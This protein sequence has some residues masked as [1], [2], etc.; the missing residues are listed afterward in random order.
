MIKTKS[1]KPEKFKINSD[2]CSTFLFLPVSDSFSLNFFSYFICFPRDTVVLQCKCVVFNNWTFYD[3]QWLITL[4]TAYKWANAPSMFIK[5]LLHFLFCACVC[6]RIHVCHSI[7][8]EI[9]GQKE[10]AGFL[11]SLWESWGL[12]MGFS[13]S[14]KQFYPQSCFSGPSINVLQ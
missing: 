12:H 7:A 13:L 9:R 1:N 6:T 8:V 3:L 10:R 5:T 11:L 4:L 2:K 14:R